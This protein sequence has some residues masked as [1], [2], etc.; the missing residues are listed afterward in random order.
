MLFV[1][2]IILRDEIK[3]IKSGKE[4]NTVE[5]G[6]QTVRAVVSMNGESVVVTRGSWR[7]ERGVRRVVVK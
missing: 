1:V 2:A 4:T 5:S 7:T 6:I 3:I